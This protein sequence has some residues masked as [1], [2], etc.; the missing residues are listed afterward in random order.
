[1]YYFVLG[2]DGKRYGPADI[3]TLVK[4]VA[5]GRLV[6]ETQLIERGT[7]RQLRAD[8]IEAINAIL[9]R[10]RGMGSSAPSGFPH[11]SESATMTLP[12][13][14]MPGAAVHP[15]SVQPR[16]VGPASYPPP[17]PMPHGN[18]PMP[19]A[20]FPADGFSPKSKVVAG[21]LGLFLGTFGVHRFYLGY[22][23][24]G[25]L[26]LILGLLTCGVAGL[27]GFVE[28]IVCLCGGMTDADGYPLRD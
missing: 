22:T 27:W 23:G 25:I 11:S 5:E 13:A 20:G 16:V 9:R 8:E 15:Q 21:L 6:G 17:V 18:Y 28:G 4:W 19:Y 3:D 24:I 12:G 2:G 14:H 10:G 7:E 1:M 26:Q